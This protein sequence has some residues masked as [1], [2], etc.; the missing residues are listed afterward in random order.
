MACRK[1][2]GAPGRRVLIKGG[3]VISMDAKIGELPDADVLIDGRTILAVG[4]Q[5]ECADAVVIEAKGMIVMPGFIDTHHHQF[6]TALR[7]FLADGLLFNDDTR[8]V[9]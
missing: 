2:L 8:M 6:E 4:P 9:R 5:L 1:E 7:G 3:A